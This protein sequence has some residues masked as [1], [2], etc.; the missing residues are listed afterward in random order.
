[1]L[2]CDMTDQA[3]S[4]AGA[5]V[6]YA[7]IVGHEIILA[8]SGKKLRKVF[9]VV[10]DLRQLDAVRRG[11]MLGLVV[12]VEQGGAVI[13]VEDG[14]DDTSCPSVL[15]RYGDP[16]NKTRSSFLEKVC[17]GRGRYVFKNGRFVAAR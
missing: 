14:D 15:A 4:A 10:T 8:V 16:E 9:E 2:L 7:Y 3:A 11:K 12:R 13:V 6:H 1:M 5:R 17:K